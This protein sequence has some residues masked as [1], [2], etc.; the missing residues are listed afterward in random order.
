MGGQFLTG[1]VVREVRPQRVEPP[2][3]AALGNGNGATQLAH[4]ST[5]KGWETRVNHVQRQLRIVSDHQVDD[6]SGEL[7]ARDRAAVALEMTEAALA[8]GLVTTTEAL[9]ILREQ[10]L[11]LAAWDLSIERNR[12]VQ[13]EMDAAIAWLG[14]LPAEAIARLPAAP[15]LVAD[16]PLFRGN[17]L[18]MA[19]A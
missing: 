12:E 9:S 19:V 2:W 11:S 16:A 5:S 18:R 15:Q 13:R 4:H 1:R 6:T 7:S 8:D 3:S 17:S 10:R 14:S